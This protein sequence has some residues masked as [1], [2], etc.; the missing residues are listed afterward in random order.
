MKPGAFGQKT[1]MPLVWAE[2][3]LAQAQGLVGRKGL[4]SF[5][6]TPLALSLLSPTVPWYAAAT[7]HFHRCLPFSPSLQGLLWLPTALRAK[8]TLSQPTRLSSPSPW[9][10][11]T[12][13]CGHRD[14]SQFITCPSHLH[15]Y[16]L[17]PSRRGAEQWPGILRAQ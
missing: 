7:E 16:L 17:R 15:L 9:V 2:S 8:P 6:T 10:P 13:H 5:P 11:H 4:F 14:G 12:T 3:S 1:K